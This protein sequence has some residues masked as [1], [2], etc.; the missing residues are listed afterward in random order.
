MQQTGS[1]YEIS[2]S[3][4]QAAVALR[5]AISDVDDRVYAVAEIAY[6]RDAHG[7]I[8]N[9]QAPQ[10]VREDMALLAVLM[11][12]R[13]GQWPTWWRGPGEKPDW[14]NHTLV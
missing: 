3:E 2:A 5:R 10:A 4:L 12:D 14:L 11:L 1:R 7:V 9:R 8:A 6:T 13:D